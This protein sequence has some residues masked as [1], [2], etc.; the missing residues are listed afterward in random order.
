M[1]KTVFQYCLIFNGIFTKV[2]LPNRINAVM[3][4]VL[5]L[6]RAAF[7]RLFIVVVWLGGFFLAG[8]VRKYKNEYEVVRGTSTERESRTL[9]SIFRNNTTK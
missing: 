1:D 2:S 4:F 3:I 9:M 6:L 5:L 8:L 7:S